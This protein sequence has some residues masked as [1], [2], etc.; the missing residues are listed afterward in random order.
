MSKKLIILSIL[1]LAMIPVKL[2]SQAKS[3]FTGDM[4]KFK[5]ELT[6]FMGPNLDEGQKTN[7][8]LFLGKWD[9]SAFNKQVNDKDH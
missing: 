6:L 8:N 9:S 1:V 4:E 5:D 3:A 2:L 7:L